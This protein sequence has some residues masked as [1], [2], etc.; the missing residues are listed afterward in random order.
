VFTTI[1]I[2]TPRCT[3]AIIETIATGDIVTIVDLCINADQVDV[4]MFVV[5]TSLML[6]KGDVK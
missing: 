3:G 6:T 4:N 5:G 2:T 1:A